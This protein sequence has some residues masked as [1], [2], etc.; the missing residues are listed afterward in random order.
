MDTIGEDWKSPGKEHHTTMLKSAF[1]FP[2]RLKSNP[3]DVPF[4]VSK[5]EMSAQIEGKRWVLIQISYGNEWSKGDIHNGYGCIYI[6]A[7]TC[8]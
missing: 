3:M 4:H 6:V 8:E 7:G 5:Q 1:N 2:V